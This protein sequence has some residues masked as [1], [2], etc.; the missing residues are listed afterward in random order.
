MEKKKYTT[1]VY[2]YVLLNGVSLCHMGWT[3]THY[4]DQIDL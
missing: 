3:G 4:V 1:F 2:F